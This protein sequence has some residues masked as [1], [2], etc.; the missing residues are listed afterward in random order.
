MSIATTHQD[1][2][3]FDRWSETY[4]HSLMQWLLFDRLHRAI[5]KRLPI[6]YFPTA[7]LDIGCGTGRLIRRMQ[8][9]WPT[10][11]FIGIDASEGM[12]SVAHN[13]TREATFYQASAEHFPL[14]ATSV[15]LVTTTMSFHHWSDQ[16]QGVSE[17]CRVLRQGGFFVLADTNIGHGSPL[18]RSQVRALF[19][20]SNLALYSQAS[21]IPYI[22]ITIGE[23]A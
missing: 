9:C 6:S 5:L 4:E 8:A 19:Q 2:G 21:F 12:V 17:T 7:I 10:A 1:Q 22:T 20:A 18:S 15:D 11:T 14:K 16:A 13:L 3:H 23:K